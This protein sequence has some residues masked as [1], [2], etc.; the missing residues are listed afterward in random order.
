MSKDP[1]VALA[2]SLHAS[3]GAYAVLLGSGI[4]QGAGV[5]TGWEIALDLV[6]R[7]ATIEG[8][9]PPDDPVAWYAKRHGED[10]NYSHLLETLAPNP[11]DR[12]AL[13]APYFEPTASDSDQGQKTPARSH[14]A[15][16]ELVAVGL[17][18]IIVTT[19]FDRLTEHALQE[20][21]IE[22]L[23]I[24]SAADAGTAPPL[25]AAPCI[26]IK[27]NGDRMSPNLK[28]TLAELTTYEPD[29]AAL[30]V[31]VFSDYGLIVC[32]WSADWDPALRGLVREHQPSGFSCFWAH[33]GEPTK[34][35]QEVIKA[36]AAIPVSV[37][38]A[39]SFFETIASKVSALR[40]LQSR[41]PSTAEIAV[42]EV[43]RYIPD[44]VHRIRLNDLVMTEVERV[45]DASSATRMPLDMPALDVPRY[46][47]RLHAIEGELSKLAPMMATLAFHADEQRHDDLITRVIQRLTTRAI[48]HSGKVLL[49]DAQRYPAL[50]A[51][52]SAGLAALATRRI[53]PIAQA[54]ATITV[55]DLSEPQMPLGHILAP[56]HILDRDTL[57]SSGEFASHETPASD[58]VHAVLRSYLAP[59][60]PDD[61]TYDELFDDLE[62][63]HGLASCDATD[64]TWGSKGRFTWRRPHVG[65]GARDEVV[66]RHGRDL[67]AAGMFQGSIDRLNEMHAAYEKVL[68]NR[69]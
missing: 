51:L 42:A 24:A 49:I 25:H 67:V 48:E 15:L 2:S 63:L 4:S 19:N 37:T 47:E 41:Q 10:I 5:P 53:R 1:I 21:G 69:R 52:Y 23:V 59:F 32:G 46:M 57:R 35:G 6:R 68:G 44:P 55:Q 26:V 43:K 14:R 33:R 13:L 34:G 9:P 62:Y 29:L 60:I 31:R 11:G 7:L 22:P 65:R 61:R 54:F 45:I 28:N 64:G 17:I 20:T 66:E 12:Q 27:V 38:D 18:K 39:D 8:E 3:P 36:R 16:A 56:V 40:E 50:L 30:L 58:V